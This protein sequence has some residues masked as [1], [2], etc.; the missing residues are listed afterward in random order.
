MPTKFCNEDGSDII[1]IQMISIAKLDLLEQMH[2]TTECK[3][4]QQRISQN[5]AHISHTPSKHNNAQTGIRAEVPTIVIEE[6]KKNLAQQ[7]PDSNEQAMTTFGKSSRPL[8]DKEEL[9]KEGIGIPPKSMQKPQAEDL[10]L[11][12]KLELKLITEVADLAFGRSFLPIPCWQP[13]NSSNLKMILSCAGVEVSC[14][15]ILT[16]QT[17]SGTL[18]LCR[19]P[20]LVWASG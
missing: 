12:T 15:P 8:I 5:I 20:K 3:R 6:L 7:V 4:Q 17:L 10:I 19:R 2:A 16:L 9:Q 18:M 11:T 1:P 13:I 14:P